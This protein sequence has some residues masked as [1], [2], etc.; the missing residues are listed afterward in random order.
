MAHEKIYAE[1][2]LTTLIL[3]AEAYADLEWKERNEF[4]YNDEL[5]DQIS[6]TIDG[7]TVTIVCI[8]DKLEKQIIAGFAKEKGAKKSTGKYNPVK[9]NY[10]H[11][12]TLAE[13]SPLS[14]LN[15]ISFNYVEAKY[16]AASPAE[17]LPPPKRS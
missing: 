6:L 1:H 3:S 5:Y 16:N 7:K 12:N 9:I 2:R 14:F 15:T 13:H 17:P 11:K 10:F 4:Y 8:N